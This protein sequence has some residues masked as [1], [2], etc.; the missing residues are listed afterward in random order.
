MDSSGILNGR[1]NPRVIRQSEP[2]Q[3]DAT[4][5]QCQQGGLPAKAARLPTPPGPSSTAG[6]ERRQGPPSEPA[7]RHP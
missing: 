4:P 6:G 3:N 5:G 2:S 7:K 1:S